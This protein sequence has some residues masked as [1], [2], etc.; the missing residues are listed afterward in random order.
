ME[1]ND[2]DV[3]RTVL[4]VLEQC[5]V[6]K[7]QYALEDARVV[8]RQGELWVLSICCSHCN[9]QAL[10]AAVVDS[11]GAAVDAFEPTDIEDV[12]ENVVEVANVDDVLD[13]HRFLETFDGDFMSLF[14]RRHRRA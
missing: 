3:R 4:S 14:S 12:T 1:S 5:S 13:M 2:F 11:E 6:C 8:E 7:Q 9:T 10:V